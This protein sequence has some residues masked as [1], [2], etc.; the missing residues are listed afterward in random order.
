MKGREPLRDGRG[1]SCAR[2]RFFAFRSCCV[3]GS[4][5]RCFRFRGINGV[6]EI[7]RQ[8]KADKIE[9]GDNGKP[10]PVSEHEVGKRNHDAP[11]DHLKVHKVPEQFF[12]VTRGKPGDVGGVTCDAV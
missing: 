7:G 12:D 8:Y 9:D 2:S 4:Q 5:F 1:V 6:P 11:A 10:D 3:G